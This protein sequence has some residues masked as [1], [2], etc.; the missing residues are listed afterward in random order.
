MDRRQSRWHAIR[1]LRAGR[2][3][4]AAG[5]AGLATV[6]TRQSTTIPHTLRIGDIEDITS[7]N[8]HLAAIISQGYMS[9]LTMAYLVRYGADNRPIPELA[10][11]VPTIKN[12]LIS[13]DGLQITWHLRRGVKWSD[14]APFDADDVVFSTNAVNNP[15]N[16]ELG[17]DG[18]ELIRKIDEPDKYTVIFHLKKRYSA[19]LPTFFGTAGANP[20]IL[21]KHI[22]GKLA[23]IN[24]APYNSKP[25]G[26]GP[27]RYVEWVRNDHVTMEANPYYWRGVPKLQKIIYKFVPDRNTLLTQVQTG[28]IDMWPLVGLGFY[29]R[30]KALP[31]VKTIVS[32]GY[33]FSH[34]DFNNARPIFK[35]KAVREALRYATDRRTLRDKVQ[36]GLGILQEGPI[37]PVSPLYTAFPRIPFDLAKANAL[38]DAAGWKRGADGIRVKDGQRLVL[39]FANGTGQPDGDQEIELIR[40][41]WQRIGVQIDLHHYPMTLMF[42]SYQHGGI[43]FASK[44]DVIFFSW[45]LTPDGDLTAE[46]GCDQMPP[47]GENDLRYCDPKTQAYLSAAKAT[48]DEADRK[49]ILARAQRQIIADAPSIVLWMRQDIFTYNKDLQRWKPN[50]T[51]P[52]D[53]MLDVDI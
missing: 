42:A 43:V 11:A 19:Y 2:A 49:P 26:I 41:T 1:E 51:T 12:H 44:F 31:N 47:A 15:Q 18:W 36:H 4:N 39:D 13:A 14:G 10:T 6:V 30:V 5:Q 32:T 24:N 53:S 27:F 21:P 50:N 20:C 37:T 46:Y 7:L 22:L 33:S 29:E 34:L 48:Y 3:A 25:I 8:P 23:N 45:Q 16:N 40:T 28:E 38:L 52:F 35:D 17:R 9:T